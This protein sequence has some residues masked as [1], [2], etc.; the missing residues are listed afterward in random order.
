[1][2]DIASIVGFKLNRQRKSLI[3]ST[4]EFVSDVAFSDFHL[5]YHVSPVSYIIF[6]LEARQIGIHLLLAVLNMLPQP[7]KPIFSILFTIVVKPMVNVVGKRMPTCKS[8]DI[9]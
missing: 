1:M 5:L 8:I 3:G 4:C 7:E 9:F 6:T 2:L